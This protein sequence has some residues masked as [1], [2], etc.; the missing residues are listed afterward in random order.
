M[1]YKNKADYDKW[2]ADWYAKNREKKIA[3]VGENQKR[4][5]K[6]RRSAY[7]RKYHARQRKE[8]LEHYGNKC[9]CCEETEPMFLTIDHIN[10]GGTKHSKKVGY[11]SSWLVRNNYPEGFRLLCIN[12]NFGRE[13][14]GGVCPHQER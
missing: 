11:L 3:Q 10:G 6:E 5:G 9:E 4:N 7:D 2:Y 12:C 8:V 1:P 14:N 13:R